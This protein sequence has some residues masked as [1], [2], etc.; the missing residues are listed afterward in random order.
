MEQAGT[1]T[2]VCPVLVGRDEQRRTVQRLIAQVAAGSGT[3]ALISGDAGIGKS[4]LAA[5]ARAS[6]M[7]RGFG[8]LQGNCFQPDVGS[9]FAPLLDMLR[10]HFVRRAAQADDDDAALVSE[11]TRLLPGILPSPQAVAGRAGARSRGAQAASVRGAASLSQPYGRA[12]AAAAAGRG[13]ALERR[14]QPR[15][16]ALPGAPGERHC[17]C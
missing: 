16:L 3:V 1:R 2:M 8:V 11:L 12:A 17:R 10:L 9:P 14:R 6:A 13:S 4:R 15:V 7:Q 5:A